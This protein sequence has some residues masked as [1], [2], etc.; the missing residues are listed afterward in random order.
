MKERQWCHCDVIFCAPQFM[1]AYNFLLYIFNVFIGWRINMFTLLIKLILLPSASGIESQ[2]FKFYP[3][4]CLIFN[5]PLQEPVMLHRSQTY[6]QFHRGNLQIWT[7][8]ILRIQHIS[9][10]P[11]S[12][13][14]RENHWNQP[15]AILWWI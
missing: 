4:F 9:I 11:R 8:V 13:N 6:C 14:G 2:R 3:K 15:R 1:K 7:A 10:C 5:I 12:N